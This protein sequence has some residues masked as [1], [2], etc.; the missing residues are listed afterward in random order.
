MPVVQKSHTLDVL[1]IGESAG[2]GSLGFSKVCYESKKR[3]G[4]LLSVLSNSC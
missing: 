2:F 3:T 1:Y 4:E